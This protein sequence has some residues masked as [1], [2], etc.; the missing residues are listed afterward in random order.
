[1]KTGILVVLALTLAACVAPP[2]EVCQKAYGFTP[3]T[4]SY[5]NCVMHVDQS[6]RNRMVDAFSN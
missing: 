3:G 4:D 1:M 6:R 2:G 5:R